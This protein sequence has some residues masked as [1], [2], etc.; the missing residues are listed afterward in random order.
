MVAHDL[1]PPG[2]WPKRVLAVRML[3]AKLDWLEGALHWQNGQIVWK[4]ATACVAPDAATLS[5]AQRCLNT[6]ARYPISAELA[7]H[8]KDAWIA[9]RQARIEF[10]KRLREISA[11]DLPGLAQKAVAHDTDAV[12]KLTRLLTAEALCRNSLPLS[13]CRLLF[14]C[15]ERAVLPLQN[16]IREDLPSAVGT[17]AA[18]TLGV[19]AAK[20]HLKALNFKGWSEMLRRAYQHG[21]HHGLPETPAWIAALLAEPEGEALTQRYLQADSRLRHFALSAERFQ[22]RMAQGVSAARLVALVEV[23]AEAELLARHLLTVRLPE[24]DIR[25]KVRQEAT[26]PRLELRR[27][28]LEAFRESLFAY[29][30]NGVEP[31]AIRSLLDLARQLCDLIG[32]EALMDALRLP[33]EA[34]LTL[35]ITLQSEWLHVLQEHR[36]EI[37][38]REELPSARQVRFND[39]RLF[40]WL[41]SR[42]WGPGRT[43]FFLL[44][45]SSHAEVVRE[46][47]KRKLYDT[48]LAYRWRDPE[49][50]RWLFTLVDFAEDAFSRH[51]RLHALCDRLNVLG[52]AS[53]ARATLQPLLNA[54]RC[55]PPGEI[56]NSLLCWLLCDVPCD[57]ST[58]SVTLLQLAQYVPFLANFASQ[59]K[60]PERLPSVLSAALEL[61]QAIPNQAKAWFP[62]LLTCLLDLEKE[63]ENLIEEA[64]L[65]LATQLAA[66]L[67]QGNE[68]R[69]RSL[70]RVF[71]RRSVSVY[72]WHI[73]PGFD[74]LRRF[75]ALFPSMSR[76]FPQQMDRCMTLLKHL[77]MATRL[78]AEALAPLEALVTGPTPE[79]FAPEWIALLECAPECARLVARY[80]HA[81]RLLRTPTTLPSGVLRTLETP[82]RR[83]QECA[84]LE[85]VLETQPER[86]DL[87]A[88]AAKLRDLL[89]DPNEEYQLRQ[90]VHEKLAQAVA[91]AEL[92]ALEHQ[93]QACYLLRLTRLTGTLPD[94]MP[95]NAD[96]M[97]ATLMTCSI[98]R[99]RRL[100]I[101]L[102]RA[103]LAG[104]S[105]WRLRHPANGTFLRNLEARGVDTAAWL[106]AAPHTFRFPH[107]AGGRVRL[108]LENDPLAILQMGNYFHTCLSFGDYNAFSTVANACELNKRVV[109]ATDGAGRVVGRKLIGINAEGALI[110]FYTYTSL[111]DDAG[112]QALRALFR[113][114][115][116]DFAARCRLLLGNEGTVPTLFAAAWYDDGVVAWSN[117]DAPPAKRLAG[118]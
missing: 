19:I 47:V 53:A 40:H 44:H 117:E 32:P 111:T 113:R 108:T 46:A 88:R 27:A 83:Q 18:L 14:L 81:Q 26:Q 118:S 70:F 97:N 116:A 105:D 36:G 59:T 103:Y 84:Y 71:V 74:L 104:D 20:H 25:A 11:P 45:H 91:E 13:P 34:G 99:N 86:T 78:G 95:F 21:F 42:W 15:G 73:E 39:K 96:L 107:A 67:A 48:I 7:L 41:E 61:Y 29:V 69:F 50:Y 76:I 12:Q 33:L 68:A 93:T 24:N 22:E 51:G 43:L 38:K 62:G 56:R 58:Q 110:G 82:H 94:G 89:T 49:L 2:R 10:A 112:N 28:V 37:W 64:M 87:G 92:A 80:H 65:S 98:T 35:S 60:Q 55:V 109:Y 54:F 31:D 114:Y 115:L 17:L 5:H 79:D 66:T 3:T 57:R 72:S 75:P 23:V 9:D 8:G 52:S 100:L 63:G 4:T 30:H 85:R 1:H 6:I 101:R 16:L 106:E 102:L 90:S 77:G